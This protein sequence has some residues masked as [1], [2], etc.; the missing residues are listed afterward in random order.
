MDRITALVE[1]RVEEHGYF[2]FVADGAHGIWMHG[3]MEIL[4]DCK[5]EIVAERSPVVPDCGLRL[6]RGNV[7]LMIRFEGITVGRVPR[8]S[9]CVVKNEDTNDRRSGRRTIGGTFFWEGWDHCILKNNHDMADI[10]RYQYICHDRVI[11][12]PQT[13]SA[14]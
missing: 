6:P 4:T 2:S 10:S 5:V 12:P 3:C 11:S 14:P 7:D 13:A 8:V 9:R 1:G